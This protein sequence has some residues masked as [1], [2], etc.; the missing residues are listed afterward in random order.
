LSL[1]SILKQ[2]TVLNCILLAGILAFAYFALAPVFIV[3]VKVPS[4]SISTTGSAA[5]KNDQTAEQQAAVPPM[6]EY[7]LLAEKNLFHPERI[8]P[9]LKKEDAVPKPEFVLYGTLIVDNVRIAYLSDKKAPRSTPGRGT[10]QTGLKL[11]ETMSGYTLKE[12][13][14]NGAVMV[15]GDDRIDLKVISPESR[16]EKRAEDAGIMPGSPAP[17]VQPA[18]PTP[19]MSSPAVPRAAQPSPMSPSPTAG[20]TTTMQPPSPSTVPPA[21]GIR[22]RRPMGR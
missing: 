15:R 6:Q 14:P 18:M 4:P 5:Q 19:A 8:V 16:K 9:P 22:T 13:S 20:Q 2:L 10:R 1:N 3:D 21:A 12:V 7:A 11:G 17:G